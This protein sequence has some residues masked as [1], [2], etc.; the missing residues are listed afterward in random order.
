MTASRLVAGFAAGFIA[1]LVFHQL[2]LGLLHV[3]G[4]VPATPW[5]MTPVPP[6]GVPQVFSA[7]FWGGVWGI[8][9]VLVEPRFGRGAAHWVSALVFGAV[10]LTLVFWFVVA[11]LK[12][13]PVG[14]GWAMPGLIV[15][16][17]VNGAWGIGTAL[18][19]WLVP[20]GKARSHP[21]PEPGR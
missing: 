16:P 3:L 8:V 11:P 6:L 17:I 7:A 13:M 15:G 5:T 19:L 12:G 1:V 14:G 18:L 21:L 9:F 20:G 2:A 10:P 4:V